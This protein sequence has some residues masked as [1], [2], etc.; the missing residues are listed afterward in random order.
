MDRRK[1]RLKRY[2]NKKF[3]KNDKKVITLHVEDERELYNPLDSAQDTLA[4]GVMEYL[5]RSTETL[6][7]LNEIQIRI[8][9]KSGIDLDNFQRCLGVHY[10][11]ENLNND[12]IDNL[13]RRKKLFLLAVAIAIVLTFMFDRTALL[14]LRNFALTLAVWEYIDMALYRDEDEEI[15]AYICE[16]LENAKVV[17]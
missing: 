5:E 7:P 1:D 11:I 13:I 6:L 16:M 9:C 14:E 4:D 15:R 10:G 12:R 8:D 3:Y 2:I 17:E